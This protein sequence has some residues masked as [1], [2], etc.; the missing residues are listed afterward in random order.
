MSLYSQNDYA[1]ALG[2][3]L[4]TGRAWPRASQTVQSAVLRA[5]GNSLQRSDNEVVNLITG[6]FPATATVMLSEWESSLGLPDD[7][8]IGESGGVSDRQRAVVAKLISTGGLNRD[9]YIR[10]AAA[11]GYTITIT[12]FRPAMS[13][14]SVCGDALNGDKWPFT[15]RINAPETTIKYVLAGAA[16]CGDPLALW[17]NKQLECAISKIAPSHLNLIFSYS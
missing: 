4:P 15:W 5:L 16:Y 7:C 14:M 3:L 6:A 1:T 10:V 2:A 13:G 11:L 9:Y 17:G 8:A 12:Q